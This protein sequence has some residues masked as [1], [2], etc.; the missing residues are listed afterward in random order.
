MG[1]SAESTGSPQQLVQVEEGLR[2][3]KKREQRQQLSDTATRMFLEQGF[4]AVKVAEIAR[5][6]GVSATTVFNYFPTKESL[7]LD[8][9]DGTA[10]AIVDAI[11]ESGG[12]PVIAVVEALREQVGFLAQQKGRGDVATVVHDLHRFGELI[13]STASMRAHFSERKEVYT[14]SAATALATKYGTY[15]TD[16][17]VMIAATALI[18]LWQV[19]SDALYAATSRKRTIAQVRQQ[20]DAD[21]R[22]AGDV[23]SKG[24]AYLESSLNMAG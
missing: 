17:R 4:D 15:A 13:R 8:R 11:A 22:S 7:L 23:I 3:R 10:A 12:D 14:V 24:L 18:G 1:M 16:P 20:V 21:L 6:C 19:Q 5:T 2:A 9:L